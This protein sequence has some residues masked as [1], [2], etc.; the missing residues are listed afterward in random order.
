MKRVYYQDT[1]NPV[2]RWEVTQLSGGMYLRQ[3]ISGVQFGK[4]LRTT[5]KWIHEIGIDQMEQ[6]EGV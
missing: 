3:F 2:K 4:G 5:K 6:V 1:Y